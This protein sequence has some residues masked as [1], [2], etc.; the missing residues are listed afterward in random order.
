MSKSRCTPNPIGK[1][2]PQCRKLAAQSGIQGQTVAAACTVFPTGTLL[3]FMIGLLRCGL[4]VIVCA[5]AKKTG[6][7]LKNG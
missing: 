6:L 3:T 4:V 1:L 2:S 7:R 5:G